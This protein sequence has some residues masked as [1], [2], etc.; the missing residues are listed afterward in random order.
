MDTPVMGYGVP[1][2]RENGNR[3]PPIRRS[4]L[5]PIPYTPYPIPHILITPLFQANRGG[6]Q[7][8]G[9]G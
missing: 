5:Y 9:G 3:I 7:G 8:Y 1:S 6:V 2:G 4:T